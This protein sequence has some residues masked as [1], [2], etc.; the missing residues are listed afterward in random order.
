[1][2]NVERFQKTMNF[3]KADR[4]P[5]V[6]WAV[7]WDKTLERWYEEGLPKNLT[8]ENDIRDYFGLDSY[9]QFWI[10][11]KG[12]G[13][14]KPAYHG[15]GVAKTAAEYAAIHSTL[16]PDIDKW[17][18]E[19]EK[20]A[21]RRESGETVVWLTLLGFFWWPRDI[22]GIESHL[23][24]FYDQPDFMHQINQ[25]LV[26]YNSRVIEEFTAICPVDFLA[27]AEDLSYNH[28][29]MLSEDLFDE[30][31]APYYKMV[32][33]E[34]KK[35]NIIPFVDSDGDI[36][37]IIP[38][39]KRVGVEAIFPLERMAGVDIAKLREDHPDWKM[40]GAFDKT[41]MKNG[42]DAMRAEFERLLPVMKQGGYIAAVDH[43]TPPDVSID[44]YREY[45]KLLREYAEKAVQ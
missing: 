43:Q 27:F 11:P 16:Y 8:D 4:M 15:A 29:P 19:A 20:W 41:V 12:P 38:W 39:L 7:W 31:M 17:K 35:H 45:L 21:Q 37:P 9:K 14:P 42:P 2:T 34:V 36:M 3:E 24:A 10:S 44:M 28:G 30:F 13:F 26:E 18:R 32:I 40:M 23:F 33:P 6:E 22:L 5:V 25:E 1:M